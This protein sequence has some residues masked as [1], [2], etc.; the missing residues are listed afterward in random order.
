VDHFY[1]ATKPRSRGA[2]WSIFAPALIRWITKKSGWPRSIIGT[3]RGEFRQAVFQS[4]TDEDDF[5]TGSIS[6][7]RTLAEVVLSSGCSLASKEMKAF[8]EAGKLAVQ[9]LVENA[10][11]A[12]EIQQEISDLAELGKLC[13]VDFDQEIAE[14]AAT[15][16]ELEERG[17]SDNFQDPESSYVAQSTTDEGFDMDALFAGLL[18]K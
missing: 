1:T 16:T 14:L 15:A 8:H 3:C 18:D 17:S 9:T 7:L 6:S 2:S 4:L 13:G 5:W 11:T 10:E 12:D